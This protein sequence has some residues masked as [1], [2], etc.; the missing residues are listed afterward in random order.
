MWIKAGI[1]FKDIGQPHF[2]GKNPKPGLSSAVAVGEPQDSGHFLTLLLCLLVVIPQKTE[3]D[4]FWFILIT[5]VGPSLQTTL[6][7][8]L[9]SLVL[10]LKAAARNPPISGGLVVLSTKVGGRLTNAQTRHF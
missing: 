7:S 8:S 10:V 2:F 5:T 6:A 1:I 3:G 9:C 4:S